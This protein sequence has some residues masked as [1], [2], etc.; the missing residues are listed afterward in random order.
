MTIEELHHWSVTDLAGF[1][2]AIWEYFEVHSDTPYESVLG[3][4]EM[5][6]AQWF[7]GATLNYAEHAVAPRP[8]APADGEVAII[9]HSQTRDPIELTWGELR[10]QVARAR[11]GLQ[12]LGVRPGRP[13]RRVPAEHPGDAGGV[14][15]HR[16]PGRDLGGL[17][18]GVR[19]AQRH[20]PVRADRTD[21]AADDRRV[22]VRRK[23]IDRRGDVEQIRAGLPTVTTV[24]HVPYGPNTVPDSVELGRAAG[25]ARGPGL[26]A[27]AVR[28]PAVRAV[29]LRHHRQTEGDRALPRRD[30][31]RAPE[32]PFPQLGPRGRATGCCGS[33]PPP[34]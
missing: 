25:R 1:W 20:R 18:T 2:S 9:A 17:R 26:R 16:Q 4:R 22:R 32:K 14:P 23:D 11:N 34:G 19:R 21:R 28:A 12:R 27:G 30:P 7:P 3:G 13:G 29:L 8:D 5:P 10:D 24:V 6:G 31:A 33:P 15:G